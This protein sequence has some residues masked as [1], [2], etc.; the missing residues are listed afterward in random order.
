VVR[1]AA[2]YAENVPRSLQRSHTSCAWFRPDVYNT[3]TIVKMI[4]YAAMPSGRR[5]GSS[6]AVS[7]GRFG[8]V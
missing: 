2:R 5:V 6:R 7:A 1:S 4:I 8:A 3:Y